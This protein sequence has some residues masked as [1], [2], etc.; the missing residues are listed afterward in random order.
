MGSRCARP[1]VGSVDPSRTHLANQRCGGHAFHHSPGI[2][3]GAARPDPAPAPLSSHDP[4]PNREPAE[5]IGTPIPCCKSRAKNQPRWLARPAGWLL[6]RTRGGGSPWSVEGAAVPG[7]GFRKVVCPVRSVG[8]AEHPV[9]LYSQ[10][11]STERH[12]QILL[13]RGSPWSWGRRET[14]R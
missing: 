9:H 3:A 2:T 10:P 6:S 12:Y 8:S 1:L 11:R 7:A 13:P 14:N 4:G 5:R